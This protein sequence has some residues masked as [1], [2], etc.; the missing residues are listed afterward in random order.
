MSPE[1]L[2][3]GWNDPSGINSC[4]Y[5]IDRDLTNNIADI[6]KGDCSD[7]LVAVHIEV[8]FHTREE[9]E[10]VSFIRRKDSAVLT[11]ELTL[12]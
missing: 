5:Q 7:E 11:A 3:H 9:L 10:Q 1:V 8:F 6:P 4:E 2:T 12:V